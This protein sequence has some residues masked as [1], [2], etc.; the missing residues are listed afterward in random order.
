MA[1]LMEI[2]PSELHDPYRY[3][4]NRCV[5]CGGL[6]RSTKADAEPYCDPCVSRVARRAARG[7]LVQLGLI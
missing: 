7:R 6:R 3:S 1:I 2:Q 5:N 4:P